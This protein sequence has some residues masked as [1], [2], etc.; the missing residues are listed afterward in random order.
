MIY[1]SVR[2]I[3]E[4]FTRVARFLLVQNAK[5]VKTYPPNGHKKYPTAETFYKWPYNLTTFYIRR[6]SEIHPNGD[7]WYE[8]VPSGNPAVYRLIL[9]VL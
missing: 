6:P 1:L 8:N 4:L 3:P 7:F 2:F 9:L 5:T